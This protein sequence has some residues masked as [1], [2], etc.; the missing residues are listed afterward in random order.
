MIVEERG[1]RQLA[2]R[3]RKSTKTTLCDC[4]DANP[5]A[6][7]RSRVLA[8]LPALTS[9]DG[10]VVGSAERATAGI[11]LDQERCYLAVMLANACVVH[12]LVGVSEQKRFEPDD[13]FYT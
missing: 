9:L 6:H 13:I 10:R 11:L 2:N 12:K 8:R 7:A 3:K 4:H 5:E 1:F